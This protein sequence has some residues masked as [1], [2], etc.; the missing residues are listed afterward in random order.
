MID[1]EIVKVRHLIKMKDAKIQESLKIINNTDENDE[2]IEILLSK[3]IRKAGL[4]NSVYKK[5]AVD[6]YKFTGKQ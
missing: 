1:D 3:E 4:N 5:I 2:E 6:V